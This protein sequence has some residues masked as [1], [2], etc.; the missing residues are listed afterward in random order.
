M[1]LSFN[2]LLVAMILPTIFFKQTYPTHCQ[3]AQLPSILV[4]SSLL[5]TSSNC[6]IRRLLTTVS[7][8]SFGR[9]SAVRALLHPEIHFWG[10][11]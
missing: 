9:A 2:S 1:C 10:S 3:P 7:V 11:V 6:Y 4:R 5:I 8:C